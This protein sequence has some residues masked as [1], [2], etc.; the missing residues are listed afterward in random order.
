MFFTVEEIPGKGLG[1]KASQDIKLG[2]HV[3]IEDSFVYALTSEDRRKYCQICLLEFEQL[4]AC[5]GCSKCFYCSRDCQ[6]KGW[7]LHKYECKQLKKYENQPSDKCLI[8]ARLMNK[9]KLNNDGKGTHLRGVFD[10]KYTYESSTVSTKATL[11]KILMNSKKIFEKFPTKISNAEE[12]LGLLSAIITNVFGI[13]DEQ[14]GSSIGCGLFLNTSLLNHDC[15]P[16]CCYCFENNKLMVTAIRDIKNGEEISIPYIST[17]DTSE[18]RRKELKE[19]FNFDCQCESCQSKF[20]DEEMLA[21][22]LSGDKLIEVKEVIKKLT[23][24]TMKEIENSELAS[25]LKIA[26]NTL[27]IMKN[28]PDT[29][30]YKLQLLSLTSCLAIAAEEFSLALKVCQQ[31]LTGYRKYMPKYH[32]QLS[33]QYLKV[34]KLLLRFDRLK[35][36]DIMLDQAVEISK[37]FYT[38]KSK[39]LHEVIRLSRECKRELKYGS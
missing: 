2:T 24:V 3:L 32:I 4:K 34:A 38:S 25:N 29:Y 39:F 28:T 36:A 33:L 31:V 16:N 5:S 21:G 26:K 15:N 14:T 19:I 30:I 10:L 8:F 12:A 6:K 13:F 1:L 23:L 37:V 9:L 35:E 20:Q 17:L 11:G 7:P 18:G 22:G 27:K